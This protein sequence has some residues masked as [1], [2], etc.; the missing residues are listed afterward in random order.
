MRSFFKA[1][2]I[3]TFFSV[4][5]RALGFVLRI[6]LSRKL[7]AEML[8]A[9][10]VSMSV[11]GV[12]M[13]LIAS[14]IPLV[15]SRSSA[16]N[17]QLNKK[18]AYST[19]S[20][21][22]VITLI[23]S[24]LINVV[25]FLFPSTLN[26]LSPQKTST[27]I[28]LFALPSLIFSAVY[29]ILRSSLWGNKHFFAIS[30]TEF[31]E[32][33]VRIALCLIL[34]NTSLLSSLTLG[35]KAS[36]SLSLACFASCI[37]VIIIYFKSNHKLCSP[38]GYIKPVLKSSS[39]I[40]TLRTVSSFV[41]SLISVIIPIRLMK[42]GLSSSEALAEFGLV[43]GMAFPLIMIPGTLIGSVAV[44]LV[45]EISNKTDNI[46]DASRTHDLNGLKSNILTG[47]NVSVLISMLLMPAFMVLGNP[48]CEILFGSNDAGKYVC[49]GAILM[50]PLG[51]NQITSSILNSI[52]LEFKSLF[53]YAL[54]AIILIL[55]IFFLPKYIGTYSLILGFLL[56][57]I[58]SASLNIRMLKKRNLLKKGLLKFIIYSICFALFSALLSKL[59][60]N[61]LIKILSK[62][63]TTLIVGIISTTILI[64]LYFCFNV[65]FVKGFIVGK[66]T[67][68]KKRKNNHQKA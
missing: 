15:V 42:A 63:I 56:M 57:S 13:T 46:D 48:I 38:K 44:T 53:N 23:I 43:M 40:T 61:L 24:I 32:Q 18:E 28:V 2:L 51:I 7:G 45:P 50:L 4:I 14:G 58:T 67:H 22:L 33:I 34:F 36:L 19:V 17:N 54:G 10:Q 29:C 20:A 26:I 35:E 62:F 37:L 52:G 8:G 30:F 16:Y 9:Y 1:T 5:T 11:L 12:L 25:L 59:I 31:F 41:T 55:S 65:S 64:L 68:F 3:V 47:I 39:S 6:I 60:Y 66:F 49:A 21:G 27:S